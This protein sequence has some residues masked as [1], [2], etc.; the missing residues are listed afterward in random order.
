MCSL[1]LSRMPPQRR[2]PEHQRGPAATGFRIPR[3]GRP[4]M[5]KMRCMDSGIAALGGALIGAGGT[6][7]TAWL[8]GT[9]SQKQTNAQLSAQKSQLE[10]RLRAELASQLREP[11]RKAYA[12]FLVAAEASQDRL[13][14]VLLALQKVDFD[15]AQTCAHLSHV[16]EL[17]P[18]LDRAASIARLEGPEDIAVQVSDMVLHLGRSVEYAYVWAFERNGSPDPQQPNPEADMMSRR[19]A[20]QLS[21]IRFRQ[22]ATDAIRADGLET[23]IEQAIRRGPVESYQPSDGPATAP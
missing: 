9:L 17:Q 1:D 13:D 7:V 10:R 21:L 20:A 5:A 8:T 2:V 4:P 16:R 15:F 19:D 14:D 11:R 23:D 12:D 18:E 22:R 6:A 3:T